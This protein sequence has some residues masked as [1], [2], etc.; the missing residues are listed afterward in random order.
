MNQIERKKF[1]EENIK[2]LSKYEATKKIW[3]GERKYDRNCL[4]E[5]SLDYLTEEKISMEDSTFI[6][7]EHGSDYDGNC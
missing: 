3:D 1:V 2:K 4:L 5:M 7:Y 6:Y